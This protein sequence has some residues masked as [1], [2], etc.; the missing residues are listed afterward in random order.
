MEVTRKYVECQINNYVHPYFFHWIVVIKD[1]NEPIGTIN[2]VQV[3]K[4]HN[5]VE[6][7]YCY[8]VRFWNKGYGTEALKAFI[9]Y[10]FDEVEV[11]KII[12][13]YLSLNSASGRVMEK[14]GMHYDGTLKNYFVD[15][16]T[17]K[18]CDKICYS[19]DR[20]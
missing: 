1:T 6:V 2:A 9:T 3:S 8:G 16:K 4:A 18:R 10:L 12:A 20:K 15:K 11:D 14:A 13:C 7:G 5:L 19:I 17:G